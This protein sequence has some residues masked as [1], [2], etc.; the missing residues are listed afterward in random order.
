M[1]FPV[2]SRWRRGDANFARNGILGDDDFVRVLGGDVSLEM[3][4]VLGRMGTVGARVRD[5]A[6]PPQME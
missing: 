5:A 6:F 2:F 1:D 3:A 4:F